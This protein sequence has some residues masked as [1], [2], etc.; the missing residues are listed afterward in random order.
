VVLRIISVSLLSRTDGRGAGHDSG[1]ETTTVVNHL[2]YTSYG[3]IASQTSP[4]KQP[5]YTYTTRVWD[6]DS[7]LYY[8]RARWYDSAA[9]RFTS[10]DPIG[11]AGGE[12][13]LFRYVQNSPTMF[14][15]PSG[16]ES[17]IPTTPT[18]DGGYVP[19]CLQEYSTQHLY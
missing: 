3:D 5:Y 1:T 17:W 6:G 4:A 15:D 9:G 7:D 14:S 11:F 18:A 8:Y 13:N 2:T 16:H 12:T 19:L 10:E